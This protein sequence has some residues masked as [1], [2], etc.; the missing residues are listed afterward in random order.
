MGSQG[1]QYASSAVLASNAFTRTGY[2]FTG[3]NTA[4]NGSGT[5]YGNGATFGPMPAN[6]VTLYAQ[7]SINTYYV[8]FDA[9]GGG[10]SMANQDVIY[11]ATSTLNINTY[12]R[13]GYT[14]AGWNTAADGSGT[15]YA[16]GATFGP[17]PANNVTLYAQWSVNSYT[18]T[19]DA[20]GG[21]GGW[22]QLL[23]YGST[24]T[25]PTVTRTGY[26]FNSW[27]PTPPGTVPA[28][29]ATYT[30]QWTVNT[31]YVIFNAN[32]GSGSMSNQ[33]IQYG[34]SAA[35]ISN[36]FIRADYTFTGWNTAAD[37]SGLAYADEANFGPMGASNVTLY[38]QWSASTYYVI[39]NAN[40]GSGFM[41]DQAIIFGTSANLNENTFT[42]QGHT[43]SGWN[44]AADG[45][46]TT[47]TNG[48]NYG[49]MPANNVTL[50]AQWTVNSYTIT[51]DANGGEG[52]W[53][54]LLAYGSNISP[55]T[56]NREGYAFT[57]WSPLPPATVPAADAVYTAQWS[58][59]TYF[60]H[61][62]ANGGSGT[63]N[64]QGIA[65]G[66]TAELTSNMFSYEGHTFAGWN[67][68][69]DGSGASYPDGAAYGPMG[70]ADVTL[71]AQWNA[72]TYNVVF[73]ANGGSGSMPNQGIPYNDSAALAAGTFTRP[74]YTFA[75]WNTAA[76][77]SGTFFADEAVYGPMGAAD[78]TLYA[79]WQRVPVTLA[80][81]TGSTTVFAAEAGVN[82]IYGL[83]EGLSEQ[84]FRN[85]FVQVG[86][87][88]RLQITKVDG[89]FGTG[90]RV[91]LYDN[92]TN[93]L[94][95]TYWVVIF[96]DVDGDGYVTAADENLIDAAASYQSEFEYG[97]AA[98]YAA[99]IMQDGGVDALD[100]N[101]V[102]AATSYTGV[103]DQANPGVI[104]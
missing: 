81:R 33:G 92:V 36:A 51:F 104:I 39:F 44:T 91:D 54:Q 45:S 68:A 30:A 21:T 20:N 80:K 12:L 40:G 85:Q 27:S 14:F 10:G 55:P 86:G 5:S 72:N 53:S 47:Y 23:V 90:T 87:D 1:I 73:D 94:L 84:A 59:N 37:G 52:G 66:E 32:G 56:V 100:L 67:T 8:I 31:Y 3:W 46:G 76:D 89:S 7:W 34:S 9:N 13:T 93:A 69:A 63:M 48:G 50:Y 41:S 25:P 95:K 70:A 15:S 99:D 6:N 28:S 29:N 102:S 16:N 26:T 75:G 11:G 62:D 4:A 17:M 35:L 98:F 2:T 83:E 65:Y 103:L 60:V 49:P 101:I 97:T 71:Y 19:F 61:F 58:V 18:I 24:L 82:Y 22:S 78:V 64:G 43:F 88:G 74:Y 96:G 79:V 38:A 57:G 77:G 42:R